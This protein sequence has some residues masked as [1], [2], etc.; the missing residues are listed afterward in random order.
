VKSVEDMIGS[1][2]LEI[3]LLISG[4]L[5]SKTHV[6]DLLSCNC[7]KICCAL[8]MLCTGVLL[9]LMS[10]DP[11]MFVRHRDSLSPGVW[12]DMVARI[13]RLLC[14]TKLR[15]AVLC[16]ERSN[17]RKFNSSSKA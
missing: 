6:V 15:P 8:T 13:S 9:I 4:W 5:N 10:H 3:S 17:L 16:R 14:S 12:G 2:L 1:P 7:W 11:R